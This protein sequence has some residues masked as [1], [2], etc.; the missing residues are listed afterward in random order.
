MITFERDGTRF[1][2]RTVGV[3]VEDG[4]ALLHRAVR[5]EFW[6]LPGG[7]VEFGE[8]SASAL[9]RELREELGV[10]AEVGRLLWV[11][12]NFFALDGTPYHELGLYYAF[13]LPPD[14]ALRDKTREHAGREEGLDAPLRLI[15]R[16]FPLAALADLPLYPVFLRA[17][18]QRLPQHTERIVNRDARA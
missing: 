8:E 13:T 18:L 1:T 7:R 17:A 16:W 10:D 2:Y 6:S 5:D 4:W 3:C 14:S 12:E 9:G 11:V 15:F